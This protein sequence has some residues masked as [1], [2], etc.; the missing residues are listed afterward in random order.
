MPLRVA[1]DA[2]RLGTLRML[3]HDRQQ[4]DSRRVLAERRV[5]VAPDQEQVVDAGLRHRGEQRVQVGAVAH[6]P[7]GDVDGH[8]VPDRVQPSGNRDRLVGSVLGRAGDRQAHGM[9]ETPGLFL[10]AAERK[11][12][13]PRP[14]LDEAERRSLHR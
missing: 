10:A 11:H 7:R 1:G 3:G 6:H 14:V 9:R 8:R 13:E 2:D 12:L 4:L 5:G